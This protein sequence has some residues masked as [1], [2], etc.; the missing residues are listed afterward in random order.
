ML[1][2]RMKHSGEFEE[3]D[4]SLRMLVTVRSKVICPMLGV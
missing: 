4:M 3:L 1:L 2:A